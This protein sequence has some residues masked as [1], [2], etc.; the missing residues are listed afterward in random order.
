[1]LVIIIVAKAVGREGDIQD[2][3]LSVSPVKRK[4][5][6]EQRVVN[7]TRVCESKEPFPAPVV[8]TAGKKT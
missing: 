8:N 4:T 3:V 5:C 7:L 2:A 1:M 6:N